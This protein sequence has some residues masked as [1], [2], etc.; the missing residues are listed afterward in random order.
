MKLWY[1]KIC[2]KYYFLFIK[3]SNHLFKYNGI[4]SKGGAYSTGAIYSLYFVILVLFGNCNFT[5]A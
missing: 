5:F 2:S 3:I 1:L 4:R